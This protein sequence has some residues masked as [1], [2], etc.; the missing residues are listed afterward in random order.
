MRIEFRD[1]LEFL[2]T[3]D[4]VS[5]RPCHETTVD[6]ARGGTASVHLLLDEV[7][8]GT[9]L[10]LK[11]RRGG[12]VAR[13]LH[14]YR[15]VDVP[16]EANTG[17][18]GFIEKAG[19]T[20]PDVARRAPFRV[21][22][23]MEPLR[24]CTTVRQ[25][26]TAALR[27]HVP[28]PRGEHLREHP[29]VYDVEVAGAGQTLTLQLT[30][31]LHRAT[32]PP[33]GRDSFPYTNW[34]SLGTMASRHGLEP[35]S[36]DHWRMI[37]R[38]AQLMAHGRQN[39]FW[40]P[41]R[42]VFTLEA[43]LPVLDADR[44]S[45]LVRTFQGAGL[46]WIEG[47]HV[48]SRTGGEWNAATFDTVLGGVRATSPEGNAELARIARQLRDEIH[49]H[50]W[51][52]R[53]WQH[54]TDEPAG[55]NAVDYRILA[56]MVRRHLPGLPLLDATMDPALAGA[57]D[58]WCPQ[59]QEYQKHR[60]RFEA[61]RAL[62]DQVWFYTCCFP[63]GPWLNRLLDMELL[64]P[65]LFGWAA[66]RF[67]LDGYL[68]WGL[69]HYKPDQDPFATSVVDHGHGNHL[70]PGD[71]HIVYPGPDGP[72][73]SVRLEAQREGFEDLELLRLLARHEPDREQALVRRVLTGFDR[74]T[75]K[76]EV[77]RAARRD[78]LAALDDVVAPQAWTMAGVAARAR[79]DR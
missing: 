74:Y 59:A 23:A 52:D 30:V 55:P 79:R 7:P 71:T 61:Q 1:A 67:D 38:Y 65:C 44:L 62:G 19:E 57:V 64:R 58:I 34:Y 78:L 21:F 54:V 27:L 25:A 73:S 13:G 43:G 36:P 5:R 17:P 28:V 26:G 63:G 47:G 46:H 16:V 56:G 40:V 39:T 35:W 20:N 6:V 11:V 75:K 70:P 32:I 4:T 72:W 24:A 68:H 18:V 53:W 12:R 10:H 3:D 14:W 49:F 45:R 8:A 15:L 42:E 69:N 50:G 29:A 37:G 60:E 77:L 31:R 51:G 22:D 41:L 33:V 48:A 76:A 9:E 2:Y 66:A